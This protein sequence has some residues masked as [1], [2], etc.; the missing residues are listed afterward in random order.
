MTSK[1]RI[2]EEVLALHGYDCIADQNLFHA[3]FKS[4]AEK[5]RLSEE[6][7]QMLKFEFPSSINPAI[8]RAVIEK[9]GINRAIA[10]LAGERELSKTDY[11]PST[12]F[13]PWLNN[14]P[15]FDPSLLPKRELLSRICMI[16]VVCV[17]LFMKFRQFELFPK[18]ITSFDALKEQSKNYIAQ[19]ALLKALW[20]FETLILLAYVVAYLTRDTAKNVAKGFMQVVYPFIIA[21][22]PILI[23]FTDF[24]HAG[25]TLRNFDLYNKFMLQI[26]INPASQ[27]FIMVLLIVIFSVM[28]FGAAINLFGLFYLRRSFT[29]MAEARTLIQKGPFSIV[30]HPLYTG[31]YIMFLG[32]TLL[33]FHW[34]TVAMY[35]IFFV[36]QVYR[37]GIE[38]KKLS[39]VFLDYGLYKRKTGMFFPKFFGR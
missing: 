27:D 1:V 24:R 20:S 17:F 23:S 13:L 12:G 5:A 35:L 10:I 22:I 8:F 9:K 34:I 32:T 6:Q 14:L 38:E 15:I 33:R 30:R 25:I 3:A 11:E 4:Q 26:G 31:H 21:G 18:G 37:A 16:L 2:I 7:I 28:V 36:G 19:W 29:L 39:S